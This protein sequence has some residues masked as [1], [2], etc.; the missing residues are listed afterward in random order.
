MESFL[1]ILRAI[2][3]KCQGIDYLECWYYA[4]SPLTNRVF[5]YMGHFFSFDL[6]E[7]LAVA[8]AAK[9]VSVT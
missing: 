1:F 5:P 8:I 2:S 4:L 3:G 6:I 7:R 9:D